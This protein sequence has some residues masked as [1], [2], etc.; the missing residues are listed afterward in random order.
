MLVAKLKASLDLLAI[1]RISAPL[2]LKAGKEAGQFQLIEPAKDLRGVA[3]ATKIKPVTTFGIWYPSVPPKGSN[4]SVAIHFHGGA[5]VSL[6]ARDDSCRWGADMLAKHVTDFAFLAEYRLAS[7]E[8][9][10]FPAQLQDAIA[11]YQHVLSMGIP[12]WQ[13]V[14]GGDSAGGH[15]ALSLLRYMVDNEGILPYPRAALLWSPAVDWVSPSDVMTTYNNKHYEFDIIPAEWIAWGSTEFTKGLDPG[16]PSLKPYLVPLS[17][18]F[19][20]K[21]PL[22]IQACGLEVLHDSIVEFGEGMKALGNSVTMN[23]AP[24][25][26][27]DL[28]YGNLTGFPVEAEKAFKEARVWLQQSKFE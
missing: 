18:P 3:A 26:V 17:S 1:G 5:Y 7:R 11:A 6:S 16:A 4:Y 9:G 24:L 19:R 23:S 28:F 8:D 2:D 14:V 27:H 21:T 10:A 20:I 15:L 13:I 25:A 22:W 12:A